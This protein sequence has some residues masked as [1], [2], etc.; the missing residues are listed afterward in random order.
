M[1][2]MHV[3]DWEPVILR[4]KNPTVGT[5]MNTNGQKQIMEKRSAEAQRMAKLDREE[6]V[7]PKRLA[8]ESRKDLVA[9]R[10]ALKLTQDQ[11]NQKCAFPPH[12]IKGF[13]AGQLVPSG[14]QLNRLNKELKTSLHLE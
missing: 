1:A 11:L 3:Q 9:A 13:E 8:A 6:L 12:T 7:K 2:Q 5:T 4:G 14:G 10:V